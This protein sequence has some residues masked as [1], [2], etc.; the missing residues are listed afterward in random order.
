MGIFTARAGDHRVYVGG[1]P[2][3]RVVEERGVEVGLDVVDA[4]QGDA[5][6]EGE[7][8]CGIEADDQRGGEAGTVGDGDGVNPAGV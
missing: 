2:R 3:G 5:E 6:G 7:A 8:L 4:D 1:G